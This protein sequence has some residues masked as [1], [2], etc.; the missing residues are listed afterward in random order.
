MQYHTTNLGDQFWTSQRYGQTV[1][2]KI[3]THDGIT[4]EE[5]QVGLTKLTGVEMYI[6]QVVVTWLRLWFKV[7]A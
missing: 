1:T 2:V 4:W 5:G 7:T 6:H 3:I